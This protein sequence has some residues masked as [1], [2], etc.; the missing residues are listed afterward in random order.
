M[1]GVKRTTVPHRSAVTDGPPSG[2]TF[3]GRFRTPGAADHTGGA[4]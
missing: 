3:A 4:G 1:T 2:T